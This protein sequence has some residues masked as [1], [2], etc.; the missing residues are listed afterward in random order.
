[1]NSK[2]NDSKYLMLSK[3][4]TLQQLLNKEVP[5]N[6]LIYQAPKEFRPLFIA[7]RETFRIYV[8]AI[9]RYLYSI[10]M[11]D[12]SYYDNLLRSAKYR[13]YNSSI[14][15]LNLYR[16]MSMS[17]E[18]NKFY[19]PVK[20]FIESF[21]LIKIFPEKKNFEIAR[22]RSRLRLL[23]YSQSI[24]LVLAQQHALQFSDLD[25]DQEL[26]FKA[27]ALQLTWKLLDSIRLAAPEKLAL[28]LQAIELFAQGM[29]SEEML[30]SR[31]LRLYLEPS[32]LENRIAYHRKI[33]SS[34]KKL[35][36]EDNC[37]WKN[38]LNVLDSLA[39]Q[40]NREE[41]LLLALESREALHYIEGLL[42]KAN[43]IKEI[44]TEHGSVKFSNLK[45]TVDGLLTMLIES[46]E[47]YLA[48]LHRIKTK[49]NQFSKDQRLERFWKLL[50]RNRG[51]IRVELEYYLRGSFE[52]SCYCLDTER[53]L[54]ARF[55][56][57]VQSKQ[58]K[59]RHDALNAD[60]ILDT[61]NSIDWKK[62]LKNVEAVIKII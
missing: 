34:I 14:G 3:L 16:I 31:L 27:S 10:K 26:W 22:I 58:S 6:V 33:I 37:S 50:I 44:L 45:E 46:Y 48:L 15:F 17:Y 38:I 24:Y 7:L 20:D 40:F 57:L 47:Q 1:M 8:G 11:I 2:T 53:I 59:I 52:K 43:L 12:E 36:I 5:I 42:S 49:L 35:S 61:T 62:L 9:A 19:I 39:N 29:Q 55:M 25:Y 51:R 4:K 13:I 56:R 30:L 28:R 18:E 60:I 32:L 54:L 21:L 41:L 23:A